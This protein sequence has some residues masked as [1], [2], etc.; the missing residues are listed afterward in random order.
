MSH[1]LA[2]CQVDADAA[3][4]MGLLQYH[5][6]EQEIAGFHSTETSHPP[7]FHIPGHCHD[8]ASLYLVLEGSLTEVCEGKKR[9]CNS[10][11]VVFTPPGEKHS[12]LFDDGGGRCFLVE[13][14][15]SCVERLALAGFKLEESV[16][17]EGGVLPWLTTRLYREFLCPDP[18][19][20]LAVEGLILETLS[21]LSRYSQKTAVVAPPW[22]LEARNLVH[23][24]FSE[25]LTLNEIAQAV[26]VH[27]AHLARSFRRYYECTVGE[28][29]RRLRIEYAGRQ[30]SE[31]PTS[32]ANIA[33][34]AGFADQA[35]FSRTFRSHTGLTPA[36]FRTAFGIC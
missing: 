20:L 21:E 29:Q 25:S 19:S 32:I 31:T 7:G 12:N 15:P 11:S 5:V 14:P 27:P 8:F 1:R 30:L 2:R 17:S 18:V 33:L 35:H 22:L 36:K 10:A 9:R 28:Y 16:H 34:A 26:G 13:I 6:R 23:D 3:R 24:R 4:T